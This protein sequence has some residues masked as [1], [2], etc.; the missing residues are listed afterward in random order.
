MDLPEIRSEIC[1]FL[2]VK[3]II[4]S[5]PDDDYNQY[6]WSYLSIRDFNTK[7]NHKFE[8]KNGYLLYELVLKW[9]KDSG[10]S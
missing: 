1:K 7:L 10:K 6:L 3:D 8:N 5:F 9:K 2:G 4:V